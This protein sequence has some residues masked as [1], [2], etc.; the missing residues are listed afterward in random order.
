MDSHPYHGKKDILHSLAPLETALRSVR[1]NRK[2]L[3]DFCAQV[4]EDDFPRPRWDL[5]FIYPYLDDIGV[6][7]F[8]LMNALNFCYWGTPK[9]TVE[10]RGRLLDGA[11]GMFA[12]LKRALDEEMPVQD[13]SFLAGLGPSTVSHIFRGNV[14]IPLLSQR[15]AICRE[16]G[17]VLTDNFQGSFSRLVKAAGGSAVNLVRLLVTLFPSFDDSAEWEGHRLFFFKRAQLAP[18]MLFE[19]W[20]GT[21]IG[22]F[23]DIGELTAAADYKIPQVLRRVG[24]LEYTPELERFVD[25]KRRIPAR[26]REELEIRTATIL[27][28][29]MIVEELRPRMPGVTSQAV[30]RMLWFVGQKPSPDENPYHLTLTTAY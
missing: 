14:E 24:A 20:Q 30:D 18:A 9:W 2:S 28:C 22:A 26:S 4:N 10:Y 12:A 1:I 5:P 15:I 21:G 27:A 23:T 3:T 25:E 7:Y 13:G 8:M 19:R 6:G 16:M 17:R 29:E 11:W